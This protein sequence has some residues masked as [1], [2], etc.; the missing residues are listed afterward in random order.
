M[1]NSHDRC[2]QRFDFDLC[3]PAVE[4]CWTGRDGHLWAGNGEYES[5]VNFCPFCGYKAETPATND[6]RR[7]LTAP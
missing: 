1:S 2:E 7:P 4:Y 5:M 3:G 6:A